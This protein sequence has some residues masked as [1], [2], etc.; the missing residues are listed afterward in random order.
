MLMLSTLSLLLILPLSV[1]NNV[2]VTLQEAA[3]FST[4]GAAGFKHFESA[5]RQYLVAANF[6]DGKS[7]DMSADSTIYSLKLSDKLL[8][9]QAFQKVRGKGAH[10]ADVFT[11]KSGRRLLTIPSYYGCGS[12]RGP[13]PTGPGACASTLIMQ[14]EESMGLGSGTGTETESGRFVELQRLHT[15]GPA[16]TNNFL[17]RD[18]TMLLLIGENFNDEVCIYRVEEEKSPQ[19]S[20]KA[21]LRI[22]KQQ[23]VPVPGAGSMAVAEVGDELILAATSYHDGQTGWSTRS[24][25]FKADAR[26]IGSQLRFV[27]SQRID[28]QGAH[29]AELASVGGELFLFFSE[30]RGTAGPEVESTLLVWDRVTRTFVTHQR[31]PTDG[32]HGARMFNGPDGAAYLMVA[33]FGDRLGKRYASKSTLWRQ[34]DRGP[35]HTSAI[36]T[37]QRVAEVASYGATDA[38]HFVIDGRHFLALANEGDLQARRHQRSAIYEIIVKPLSFT[39]HG[40]GISPDEL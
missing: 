17:T 39:P 23:C 9:S 3:Q 16:Q 40:S 6:W 27:E 36:P 30:D 7:H 14:W 26:T 1:C 22:V 31:I 8:L 18:G 38:E 37:F 2:A 10:G 21:F 11:L 29:D 24:R 15:A 20:S 13:A 34:Q 28:T 4:A 32:A 33:N 12:D 25:I 5:G 19:A 35:D